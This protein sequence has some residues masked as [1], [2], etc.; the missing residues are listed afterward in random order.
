MSKKKDPEKHISMS[1]MS[2][3]VTSQ[4]EGII[5]KTNV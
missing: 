3:P 4:A 5:V 2:K 1:S